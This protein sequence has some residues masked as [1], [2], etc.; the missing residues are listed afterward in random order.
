MRM[1]FFVVP[2]RPPI[3][4][5]DTLPLKAPWNKMYYEVFER[6]LQGTQNPSTESE[7]VLWI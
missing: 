5:V 2:L 4:E 1:G 3:K 6:D 7:S